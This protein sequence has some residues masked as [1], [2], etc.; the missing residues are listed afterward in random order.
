MY[1]EHPAPLARLL[2]T[3][4]FFWSG[5]ASRSTSSLSPQALP[6]CSFL[7]H[8]QV[9]ET[10]NYVVLV[11]NCDPKS[12]PIVISGHS[13]WKNPYGKASLFAGMKGR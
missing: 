4:G 6:S 8:V 12:G 10:G 13:E 3:E 2:N 1:G 11:A 9:A 5:R 7:L